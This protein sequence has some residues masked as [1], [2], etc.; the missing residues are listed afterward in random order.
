MG[1]QMPGEL[2][3]EVAHPARGSCDQDALAGLHVGG[4]DLLLLALRLNPSGRGEAAP[5]TAVVVAAMMS[6]V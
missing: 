5:E 6:A 1:A 2:N 4:V 3:R